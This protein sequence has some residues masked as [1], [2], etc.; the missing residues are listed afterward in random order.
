[1]AALVAAGGGSG[2]WVNVVVAPSSLPYPSIPTVV[3][4]SVPQ[5][6]RRRVAVVARVP[7][8]LPTFPVGQ[9]ACD[10]RMRGGS[11]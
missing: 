10:G 1:M 6:H 11:A 2:P 8:N 7:I 3:A 5:F 4:D 9:A